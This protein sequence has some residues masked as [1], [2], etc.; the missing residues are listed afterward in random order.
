MV[1]AANEDV[2]CLDLDDGSGEPSALAHNECMADVELAAGDW[3][4]YT[5]NHFCSADE[6]LFTHAQDPTV[7]FTEPLLR[8]SGGFSFDIRFYPS[9]M[10]LWIPAACL[11]EV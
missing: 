7:S 2:A 3:L 10:C 9:H 5:L 6:E 1:Q 8:D 4:E 11:W